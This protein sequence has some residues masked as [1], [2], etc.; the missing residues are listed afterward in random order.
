MA[1]NKYLNYSKRE[2][3]KKHQTEINQERKLAT[4]NSF[5]EFQPL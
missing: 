1:L 2:D 5:Q 3:H 4:N